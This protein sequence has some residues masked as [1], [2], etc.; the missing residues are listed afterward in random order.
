MPESA[1]YSAVEVLRNGRRIEIRALRPEDRTDFLAAVERIGARS[2][3]RRFFHSKRHFT[4]EEAAFYLNVDFVSHVA[5]VAVEEENGKLVIVGGGRYGVSQPGRAELAF[6]VVDQCQ[7]QGIGAALLH[8]LI[9]I[10]RKAGLKELTAMVLPDN[11]P[12]LK[13]FERSGLPLS[14]KIESQVAHVTLQL[15]EAQRDAQSAG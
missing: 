10:A 1:E 11:I 5:I 6:T 13:V 7:G 8:H 4:D 9:V 15:L 12:M 2:R 14:K 3:Y